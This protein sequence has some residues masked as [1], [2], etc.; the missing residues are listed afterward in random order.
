MRTAG[1]RQA[2]RIHE[3]FHARMHRLEIVAAPGKEILKGKAFS[4]CVRVQRE[5][6]PLHLDVEVLLQLFNTPGSE[7]APRSYEVGEYLEFRHKNNSIFPY[8]PPF[9]AASAAFFSS[10]RAP[11]SVL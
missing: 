3:P 8:L 2:L 9:F 10:S 4:R 7:I 5:V 1:V 6:D 11:A